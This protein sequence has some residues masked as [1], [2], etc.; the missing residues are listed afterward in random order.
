MR[1]RRVLDCLGR[2]RFIIWCRIDND[3]DRDR[4]SPVLDLLASLLDPYDAVYDL[5]DEGFLADSDTPLC[6]WCNHDE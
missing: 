3:A 5:E 4:A 1:C 2:A 6:G